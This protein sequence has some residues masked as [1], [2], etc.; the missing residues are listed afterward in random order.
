MNPH[1][2]EDLAALSEHAGRLS[3]RRVAPAFLSATP[4]GR[5]TAG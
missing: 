2:D 3:G 1:I 4:R 5:W